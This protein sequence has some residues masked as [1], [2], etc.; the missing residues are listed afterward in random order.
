MLNTIQKY[1]WLLL[2]PLVIGVLAMSIYKQI[3]KQPKEET[4]SAN[5]VLDSI[6]VPDTTRKRLIASALQLAHNL[7]TAYAKYDPRYWSENDSEVYNIMQTLNTTDL[8]IIREL[9][10]KVYAKG[11]SL[12]TDLAKLLDSK[13]YEKLNL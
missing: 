5:K 3:K 1:L 13:Y 4:E 11:R 2:L 6:G 10:F 8:E 9:Y 12:D 7:G